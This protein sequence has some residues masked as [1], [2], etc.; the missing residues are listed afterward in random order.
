MNKNNMNN[1]IADIGKPPI[2]PPNKSVKCSFQGEVETPESIKKIE[3][4]QKYI[5]DYNA[6]LKNKNG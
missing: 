5:E 4:W 6:A 1:Y 2:F 3:K